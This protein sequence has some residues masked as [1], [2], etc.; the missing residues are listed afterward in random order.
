M[1]WPDLLKKPDL[2]ENVINLAPS[3]NNPPGTEG[4][5]TT[6]LVAYFNQF[7]HRNRKFKDIHTPTNLWPLVSSKLGPKL[8]K[9]QVDFSFS[10][11][12]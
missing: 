9:S 6:E 5:W 2:G 12:A 1:H 11:S 8:G 3:H 4:Y 10:H 7:L